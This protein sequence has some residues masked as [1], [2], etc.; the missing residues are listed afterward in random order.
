MS[1]RFLCTGDLHLGAGADLGREP[2]ERLA[3]QEAVWLRI[4]EMANEL[5]VPLVFAGDAWERRRP[6][7][8]ELIAFFRPLD[9]ARLEP[10]IIPGN[11][12]VEAFDRP[13]GYDVRSPEI[14]ARRFRF[15]VPRPDVV[16]VDGVVFCCL[17]WAPP[18]HLVA[19][20]EGGDRDELNH[21]LAAGL[22]EIA[23]GLHAQARELKADAAAVLLAHWNV[24]GAVTTT[25]MTV[26]FFREPTLPLGDLEA[27]GFDAVVLGHIHRPQLLGDRTF[28]VGSPM[29]LNFGEAASE[30]CVWLL[31]V[32]RGAMQAFQIPVES[33]P[34]VTLDVENPGEA[35]AGLD[36]VDGAVVKVRIRA[37]PEEARRL[38][39]AGYRQQLLDAGAWKV[40][41]VQVDV[42]KPDL[43]RAELAEDLSDVDA[44]EQWLA[45]NDLASR[46]EVL[47]LGAGYLER[48]A[49]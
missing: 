7:P 30:H 42:D 6:T 46:D 48:A 14:A 33:R 32:E 5:Q 26:D 45:L 43:V 13:T 19:L 21:R 24:T 44:L 29:P 47:A 18:G 20:Q 34:L 17:P 31:D 1:P 22:V 8:A 9:K 49:A 16:A 15:H 3:E 4:V 28:Y 41:A 25:G 38:D 35:I 23:R 10:L 37:T 40:W 36:R 12:D 11:H 39:V 2:G 27:I